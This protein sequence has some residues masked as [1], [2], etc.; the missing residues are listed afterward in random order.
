MTIDN[1]SHQ[2]KLLDAF[3]INT[4]G[5]SVKND[6][7]SLGEFSKILEVQS[8]INIT[9]NRN[10]AKKS[11]IY[12]FSSTQNEVLYIGKAGSNNLAAEI[13]GKFQNRKIP[14]N[15]IWKNDPRVSTRTKSSMT[16]GNF[17]LTIFEISPERYVSLYEVFLQTCCSI[18]LPELNKKI[19]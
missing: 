14:F 7:Y 1:I 19:G 18:D 6:Q 9:L 8:D 15:H 11:G 16:E 3:L 4:M 5:A 2:I 13:W 17:L 10:L 12:I